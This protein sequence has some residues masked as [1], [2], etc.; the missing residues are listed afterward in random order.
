[1]AKRYELPDAAW[2]L[3]AD[4]FTETRR[5]G[6]PRADGCWPTRVM[7]LKLCAVTVIVI[8]CSP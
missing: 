5:S 8:G 7:T 1:M 3:V 6:R 4:I 2:D